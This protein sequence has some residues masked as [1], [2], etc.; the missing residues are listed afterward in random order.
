MAA[1]YKSAVSCRACT[2]SCQRGHVLHKTVKVL[3]ISADFFKSPPRP[4]VK[5][6][7]VAQLQAL[8]G[9]WISKLAWTMAGR[10]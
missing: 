2:A 10:A 5:E 1:V 4:L 6:R 9:A 3:R 7:Q 8:T